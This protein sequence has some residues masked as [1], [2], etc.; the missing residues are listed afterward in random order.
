MVMNTKA[1][2]NAKE[3][4]SDTSWLYQLGPVERQ[5]LREAVRSAPQREHLLDYE[6]SDFNIGSVAAVLEEAL[7]QVKQGRGVAMIRGLPR[8]D[9]SEKEFELITWAIGLHAG[10]ARP[11]GTETR[12]LS[13]VRNVGT[14]YRSGRGRGYSSNAE[15]DYHTDSADLVFLSCYNRAASG[16][17]SLTTSTLAA[18]EQMERKHGEL[19][20]WLVEPLHFSRQGEEAPDEGPTCHQPVYAAAN[21]ELFCRWNWNRVNTAQQ[22][23]SVPKLSPLH[24]EALKCY[25]GIVRQDELVHDFWMEPGDLQIIN[26]HRTLHS[27][28]EF[29]DGQ[30]AARKRLMFRL[31]IAPPDSLELPAS[32]AELY[33]NVQAGAVRGGIRGLAYDA[34]CQ[35]FERRQ[36]AAVGA[37]FIV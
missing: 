27:R 31:W 10:V 12:Y 33:R 24:L 1:K 20:P 9:V 34:R 7:A 16:G 4:E 13:P 19:L 14:V 28:T 32:W 11:Q 26:S 2:W 30:D 25:D 21:G 17:M 23:P 6:K 29:T 22:L 18:Y 8:E 37:R 3:L 15:L 5:A 36:A 35:A